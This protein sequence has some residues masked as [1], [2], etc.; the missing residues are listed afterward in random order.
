M[1]EHV[2][3][4]FGSVDN[5]LENEA[6]WWTETLALLEEKARQLALTEPRYIDRFFTES[7][8]VNFLYGPDPQSP[9]RF[10]F[11][12]QESGSP[13]QVGILMQEFL[14]TFRPDDCWVL[15]WS[16]SCSEPV[17]GPFSGGA[18]FVTSQMVHHI[19]ASEWAEQ[20]RDEY[21]RKSIA[22]SSRSG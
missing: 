11:W 12:S 17:Q 2:L 19:Q 8:L 3:R 15:A 18:L 21:L 13:G 6:V 1:T 20:M 4:F 14:Y 16:E 9:K 5:L 22:P 10:L 7:P